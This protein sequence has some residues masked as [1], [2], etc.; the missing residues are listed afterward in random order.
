M[1]NVALAEYFNQL[2]IKNNTIFKTLF[3]NKGQIM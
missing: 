2:G 1:K 3:Y